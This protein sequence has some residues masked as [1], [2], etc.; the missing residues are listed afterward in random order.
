M[1]QATNIPSALR[2]AIQEATPNDILLRYASFKHL[3]ETANFGEYDTNIVVLDTETTGVSFRKDELTQIAAARLEK[4][5]I[6]DWY[7]TFVNPGK[8]IPDDI[9]H[10]THITDEDVADAPTPEEALAGLVKFAGDAKL[11]A[12][13][14]RFD[15]N[16]TT[17]HPAGYPLLENEWIDSLEISRIALPR[18]KSHRLIDLVKA[19]EAPVSTHRADDDVVA[20]CALYRILL[21]A[22][23]TIP[24][25]LLTQISTLAP[26]NEWPFGRIYAYYAEQKRQQRELTEL[27]D[28]ERAIGRTVLPETFSL[29]RMRSTRVSE[30]KELQSTKP[31]RPSTDVVNTSAQVAPTFPTAEEIREAFSPDGLIGKV[32]GKENLEERTEQTEFALAVRDAFANSENLIAEAGTGIGK[33]MAYLIPS[34]LTTL[35][36]NTTVGI[37]TKT[38]ALLDQLMYK[39]L[40]ALA[41][42]LADQGKDLT[43]TAL[44][45]FV[46]YPCLFKIGR[47]VDRG[48][49]MRFVANEQLSQAPAIAALLSF[50]EQTLYDDIDKLLIDYRTL[51]KPSIT[52]HSAEC[53]RRR[54]P[55]FSKECFV[56]GTRQLAESA[57]IVVTNHALLFR[58]AAA[59]GSLLPPI[60]Y[61]IVDEAHSAEDDARKALSREISVDALSAL[62][63]GLTGDSVRTNALTNAERAFA[64]AEAD[65][66]ASTLF[67]AL[68][69]KAKAAANNFAQSTVE[70]NDASAELLYFD[71]SKK[72]SYETFD[73]WINADLCNSSIFKQLESTA[74][75][76]IESAEKL[77]SPC[78]ELV[79][80]LD[81]FDHVQAAQR[82]LAAIALDLKEFA[83]TATDFFVNRTD[84]FVYSVTLNRKFKA[85]KTS[86]SQTAA[87]PFESAAQQPSQQE[88]R[89]SKPACVFH[90]EPFAISI[91]LQE[92]LFENTNSV[93]FTSATL[94]VDSAFDTFADSVGLNLQDTPTTNLRPSFDYDSHMRIFVVED[95]PEPQAPSYRTELTKLLID[96]HIAQGGSMLTLFTNKRD[97]DACYEPVLEALKE[98]DLRLVAQRWGKSTKS[99]SD[100]F[101]EDRSLSMFALK[102]FWEGFDAPGD[103]LRGVIIPKLPFGMPSDPLSCERKSR[104]SNSWSM[105]DLPKAV[106]ELRQ[107]AGR[108]IRRADDEGILILADSR[109]AKKGYGKVFLNSLPSNNITFIK[110]HELASAILDES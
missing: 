99:I 7:V 63:R 13:N 53:L 101:R 17:K 58:D 38:N 31:S 49:Q 72:S 69:S 97:L 57:D 33:S 91:D 15:R 29:R 20:T 82:D 79:A 59:E 35:Q 76:L 54:C 64:N 104:N 68:L 98:E 85:S 107:A 30:A 95:M 8:P 106:V 66:P 61:W 10:L 18:M 62:A 73:L 32:Y 56:F 71:P 46:H 11:V 52:T 65:S 43:Y 60:K 42:A 50:I 6:T 74:R 92:T 1:T 24:E 41:S 109:L 16:F 44:K 84:R 51:P 9:V 47:I 70:F 96:A 86:S 26:P 4:G 105:Y 83:Q 39:E 37:A 100:D 21:A 36:N 94:A 40:P 108:L 102:S 110:M 14:A 80:F 2:A 55:Y 77:I 93:V 75:E 88:R 81:D 87:L 67:F 23:T 27:T 28:E 5:E 34:A 78:Q 25:P 22:I 19:F 90:V 48:A 103:T 89:L 3:A 12:H 45:G